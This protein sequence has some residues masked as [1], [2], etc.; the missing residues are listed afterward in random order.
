MTL[1]VLKLE[2]DR[3][4]VMRELVE[5]KEDFKKVQIIE[6]SMQKG[7]A[8]ARLMTELERDYSISLL[9]GHGECSDIKA[10]E[11]YIEISQGREFSS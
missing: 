5:I 8:L 6:N 9:Q 2:L 1:K 3:R 10:L 4:I 11:L 7:K